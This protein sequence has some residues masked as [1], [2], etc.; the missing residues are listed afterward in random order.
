MTT[1]SDPE[2]QRIVEEY[3]LEP[4]PEGGFFK[5][6]YMSD[7]PLSHDLPSPQW[8][9]GSTRSVCTAIWY[10]CVAGGKSALH[11]IVGDELWFFHAGGPLAVVELASAAP[12]G[13]GEASGDAVVTT[14]LVGPVTSPGCRVTHTVKGGTYFG[15]YCPP[16]TSYSL[17]SC[18]VAPG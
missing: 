11:K 16:G 10:L 12:A 8:P 5:Q 7:I 15:A 1:S 18:I 6:W 9:A 17:V 4:H 3:G 13:A 2:V 14:T